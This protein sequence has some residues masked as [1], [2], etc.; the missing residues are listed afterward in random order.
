MSHSTFSLYFPPVILSHHSS[1]L[2]WESPWL[3][4]NGILSAPKLHQHLS[5]LQDARSPTF[6]L[7][8]LDFAISSFLEVIY[9]FEKQREGRISPTG[10]LLKGCNGKDWAQLKPGAQ[11]S[12]QVSKFLGHP[13]LPLQ[14]CYQGDVISGHGRRVQSVMRA[15]LIVHFDFL[16][17][18]W[19]GTQSL[20]QL[21]AG[22]K[23]KPAKRLTK[24]LWE[25]QLMMWIVNSW[26]E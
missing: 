4:S 24:N 3:L 22:C 5:F 25:K 2:Q 8:K 1:G 7:W 11:K 20:P 6:N 9:C 18:R 17:P 26:M 14:K 21:I 16:I 15:H 23:E 19:T 10:S 12:I 13:L